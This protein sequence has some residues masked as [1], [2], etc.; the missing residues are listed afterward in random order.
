MERLDLPDAELRYDP[1]FLD[2]AAADAAMAA[3]T[4]E[5]PW[6]QDELTMFGKTHPLP[7][8]QCWM[9]D[10]DTTFAYSGIPLVPAPW[11]PMVR[12]L[13]GLCDAACGLTFNSV[14]LNL[15]RDGRDHM[16]WHADDEKEVGCNPCIASLSFGAERDFALRHR[17]R[18]ELPRTVLRLTHGSLLVMRGPTQHCWKHALPKRLRVSAP[19]INLTFRV[20]LT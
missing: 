7:R 14:L 13:R 6:R 18:K 1:A 11:T 12:E 10:P 15:Y 5:V 19:R 16:G 2:T 4:T 8:L 9:G 20:I 3:L 17:T